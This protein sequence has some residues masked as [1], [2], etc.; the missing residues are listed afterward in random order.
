[1]FV[2]SMESFK[3]FYVK[4]TSMKTALLLMLLFSLFSL[5]LNH[6]Y[7]Q[8][9]VG[10]EQVTPNGKVK[11][12]LFWPEV[13]PDELYEVEL[14]FLDPQTNEP[15]TKFW[16]VY[17]VAVI[18]NNETIEVY[19][20][21]RSDDGKGLFGVVFP[22]EGTG[23][24]QVIV[25]ITAMGSG[26]TW[27]NVKERVVFDVQVVPEFPVLLTIIIALPLLAVV[28]LSRRMNYNMNITQFS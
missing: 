24:A 9:P 16:F 18:Q 15:I 1:M 26:P 6:A 27:A 14:R 7:A 23:P 13:L 4:P 19:T 25:V 11:V 10:M 21:E 2:L 12:Q 20:N 22:V 3:R 17:N 8:E 28:L 5:A